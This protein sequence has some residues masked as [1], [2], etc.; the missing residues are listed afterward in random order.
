MNRRFAP[1]LLPLLLAASAARADDKP[2][3]P[4][5]LLMQ[6]AFAAAAER[7][8]P[9][10]V[11]I[12]VEELKLIDDEPKP[13]P[14]G[15]IP[16]PKKAQPKAPP[17]P[18]EFFRAEDAP[19]TG[20]IVSA[21]GYVLTSTFNLGKRPKFVKVRLAD[22][23]EFPADVLGRDFSRGVA[24]LKIPAKDLPVP[25]IADPAAARIGQWTLALGRS[26]GGNRPNV[27]Y[28]ILSA[29]DRI[30]GRALQTDAALSPAN[31]GGPL[32]DI[33]G[34][35]LAINVPLSSEGD[36]ADAGMYDS[37]I[38]FA[39]PVADVMGH[40]D[41]LKKGEN[42]YPG[43]LGVVFEADGKLGGAAIKEVVADG[44]AG[45]AGLRKGDLITHVGGAATDSQY[46]FR[47]EI[48]RR[49]AGDT[50]ELTV[51]RGAETLKL[52]VTLGR[53]PG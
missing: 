4:A 42:L 5:V 9:S 44:P 15:V 53:R 7:A 17:P 1:A 33:G 30:M 52:P 10:V 29:K 50:V 43:F 51:K 49:I 18:P 13:R 24:L 28:G 37:G 36:A 31:Y 40:L 22:G 45:K 32:I 47:F 12:E 23:R 46:R 20:L 25:E 39:V 8:A 19:T 3:V 34:R 26:F 35:V 11:G 6:K 14:K 16:D 21:D 48:G 27:Q 2:A 38:G 41:R